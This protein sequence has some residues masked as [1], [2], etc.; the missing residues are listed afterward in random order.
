MEHINNSTLVF[1]RCIDKDI[2][3]PN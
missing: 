1:K 2:V 3:I